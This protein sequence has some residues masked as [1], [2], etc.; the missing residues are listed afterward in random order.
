M[1][2]NEQ[3]TKIVYCRNKENRE[4]SGRAGSFDFLGYTFRPRYCT[5][6]YGLRLLT[7]ACMRKAAKTSVRDKIRTFSIRKFRGN[8]QEMSG[9]VNSIIRGW[10]N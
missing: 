2:I 5:T 7:V 1:E 8:I 6:K 9:A 3:K 10:M 4:K